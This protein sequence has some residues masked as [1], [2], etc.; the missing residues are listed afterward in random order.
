MNFWRAALITL[1]IAVPIHAQIT[2]YWSIEEHQLPTKEGGRVNTI[3]VDPERNNVQY[4]ASDS[5]GLFKST[6]GGLHWQHLDTLPVLFTQSVVVVPT[7]SLENVVLVSAKADFKTKNGGGVWRS[8]DGGATWLQT[9]S[10]A[11]PNIRLSAY[12]LSRQPGTG[13]VYVGTSRGLFRSTDTGANWQEAYVAG[14][15]TIISVLAREDRVFTGGPSG[16]RMLVGNSTVPVYGVGSV[17]DM[18]AF[19]LWPQ[20]GNVFFVNSVGYLWFHAVLGGGW[21]RIHSA[22]VAGNC[23]GTPFIKVVDRA[24]E[25]QQR[26]YM[27]LSNRCGL[28]TLVLPVVSPMMFPSGATWTLADVDEDEPRDLAFAGE[29]PVLLGT[30]AGL[31]NQPLGL[32]PWRL[33]GGGRDGGYNALQINEVRG[34]LD[35]PHIDL[36][37]GT[38]DNGIKAWSPSTAGIQSFASEGHFIELERQVQPGDCNLTFEVGRQTFKSAEEL[39]NAGLFPDHVNRREAPVL[40]R[41]G[42][43]VQA[44]TRLDPTL[45][46]G[47]AQSENCA[48]PRKPFA[49]FI[50][51]P[52]GLARLGH[53]GDE[54]NLTVLYQPYRAAGD[55]LKLLRLER[56]PTSID[57]ADTRFPL[58]TGFGSLGIN[59]YMS[60]SYPVYGVDSV[61]STHVIAPSVGANGKM[62]F[63]ADGGGLWQDLDDLTALVQGPTA[64][65]LFQ[66]NLNEPN[67]GPFPLVTAVSF[68][69]QDPDLVLAGTNEGGIYVSHG[70]GA[71]GTWAHVA[72]SDGATYVTSF[73]WENANSV[74]VSTFGRGL[75]K[76]RNRR[77]AEDGPGLCPGCDVVSTDGNPTRPPFDHGALIFGGQLLGVRTEE[78]KVRELLVTRGSSVVFVGHP[79]DLQEDITITESDGGKELEPLPKGPDGW[80]AAGVVFTS[81]DELTG[82]AFSESELSLFQPQRV[83]M[84]ADS[85]DSPTK[86]T[87][88]L[89]LNASSYGPQEAI[90]LSATGFAAG[91]SY[92]VLVDGVAARD[93]VTA[94]ADGAFTISIAAPAESGYHRVAVRMKGDP[95][96]IDSA[97]FVVRN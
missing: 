84:P 23:N 64:A 17:T 78:R 36:Y 44:V 82:A 22:P 9:L 49:Y 66:T 24:V 76:L 65:R 47:M 83:D 57:V 51:A 27:Y 67:A 59:P 20:T 32:S 8:T 80:I 93:T 46:R 3:A 75:W 19:A 97:M 29:A 2:T 52:V 40:L 7:R 62:M 74:Y 11:D 14:D 5:G 73:F 38:R 45:A 54:N 43:F 13:A 56:F 70:N 18:H 48:Q 26:L 86:G 28:Y 33:V 89:Y 41:T 94:D 21:S 90:E 77:I 50:E 31:H 58:M 35:G 55:A 91:G 30:T 81:E 53:A 71:P 87:P 12:E 69:P 72:N 34:Q 6:D 15:R 61:T 95:T 60:D 10:V 79:K 92:E 39:A 63:S 1:A 42:H 25:G 37:L 16:V 88:Y 96:V 85:T 4:V 68:S